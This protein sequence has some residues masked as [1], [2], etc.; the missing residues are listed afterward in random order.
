MDKGGARLILD[1][2]IPIKYFA[3]P[4][5]GEYH[6]E[7]IEDQSSLDPKNPNVVAIGAINIRF[8]RF[9]LG[10]AEARPKDETVRR[11]FNIRKTRRG[12]TFVRA[13]REIETRDIFPR[14]DKD[15]SDGLGKWPLLQTYAYYWGMEVKFEPELDENL[16]NHKR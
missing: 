16:W 9:P 1:R 8:A 4:Q 15:E 6:L 5:T 3:D 11:R 12:V 2:S 7:K 10:F 13:G 14:S